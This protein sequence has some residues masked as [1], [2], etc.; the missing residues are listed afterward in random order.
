MLEQLIKI[1]EGYIE[2]NTN[3]ESD[4]FVY[5]I[6]SFFDTDIKILKTVLYYLSTQELPLSTR[7]QKNEK[8]CCIHKSLAVVQLSA[9]ND[10]YLICEWCK[11]DPLYD[12][13]GF[14]IEPLGK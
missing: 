8:N 10:K 7:K 2:K 3:P 12:Y 1:K 11:N 14:T 5:Y 9:H 6:T 13:V 4:S